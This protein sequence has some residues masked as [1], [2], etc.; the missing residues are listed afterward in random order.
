MT[1][2]QPLKFE[3]PDAGEETARADLYGLLATLLYAPPSQQLLD[4]IGSAGREGDGLLEKAW[5]E[6]SAACKDSRAEAVR[7]EYE[8]VFIGVGKPDVML[9]GSYYLSGFLM[10]KPLAALRADLA[11]LGLA[12]DD[13]MPE[14]EDHVAY[15]CEVMRYLI[16]SDDALHANLT[17]QKAFFA[18]HLQPWV[19]QM[20]D[21]ILDHPK[22]PFYSSVAKLARAFF[23][24]EM[25]AFDMA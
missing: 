19:L 1:T 9:Y 21:A 23:E 22:T 11:R 20:C 25:Q 15:L 10:E 24:V 3:A 18:D 8:S 4:T 12:R 17:T 7:D 2:S 5:A 6:L 16:A 13:T 14:T